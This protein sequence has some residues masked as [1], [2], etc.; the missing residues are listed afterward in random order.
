MRLAHREDKVKSVQRSGFEHHWSGH[1]SR[2]SVWEVI[3]D[4]MF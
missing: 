3:N 4:L 1:I 2:L